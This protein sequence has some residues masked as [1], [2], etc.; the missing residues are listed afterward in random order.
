MAM[1]ERLVPSSSFASTSAATLT[2]AAASFGCDQPV[3]AIA[4]ASFTFRSRAIEYL[5]SPK[6]SLTGLTAPATARRYRRDVIHGS[7]V[8]NETTN[9]LC[10]GRNR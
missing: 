9:C 1:C 7:L 6:R 8:V 5:G 10:P 4:S 3:S 2:K